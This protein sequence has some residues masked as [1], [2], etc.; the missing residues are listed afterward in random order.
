MNELE[1][2]I[3]D[4]FG[5]YGCDLKKHAAHIRII[6]KHGVCITCK[7]FDNC[8]IR[9]QLP[10]PLYGVFGCGMFEPKESSNERNTN[11]RTTKTNSTG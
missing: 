9:D 4:N 5:F 11:R 1:Q 6:V 7:R 2:Y 8:N 10:V 3:N